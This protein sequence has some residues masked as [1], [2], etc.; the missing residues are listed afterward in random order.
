MS[1]SCSRTVAPSRSRNGLPRSSR[2]AALPEHRFDPCVIH[3]AVAVDKLQTV[4]FDSNRYSVP[5]AFAFHT[6]A[7][8]GYVDRV[9]ITA[10]RPG[11]RDTCAMLPKREMI[12]EPIHYLATLSRKPGALDHAPVFRDWKLPACFVVSARA[13]RITAEWP[14]R[15][16]TCESCNCWPIIP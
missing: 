12:L 8:K 15:D 14:A 13:G 7:V 9:V 6:V 4:A 2:A 10:A 1:G 5:R 3:P 11:R 16:G